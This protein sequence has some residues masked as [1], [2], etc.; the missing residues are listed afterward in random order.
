MP[1]RATTCTLLQEAL[2]LPRKPQQTEAGVSNEKE[3]TI[4]TPAQLFG[5]QL[6]ELRASIGL[7]QRE[8]V[9]RIQRRVGVRMDPATLARIEKADG[10]RVTLDEVFILAAGLGI[11]PLH[12]M[13]PREGRGTVRIGKSADNDFRVVREWLRGQEELDEPVPGGDGE[14]AWRL[15]ELP[16]EPYRHGLLKREQSLERAR[17]R[18]DMTLATLFH[19]EAEQARVRAAVTDARANVEHAD[20]KVQAGG[21]EKRL[22]EAKNELKA[23][24]AHLDMAEHRRAVVEAGYQAMS[25]EF[26]RAR[27]DFE[28][29]RVD[30]ETWRAKMNELGY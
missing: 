5:R 26:A 24:R 12:I 17:E 27:E 10:K 14:V 28:S 20:A 19:T 15:G 9:Q 3:T 4:V 29:A 13:A 25:E 16:D 22:Q 23:A 11:S 7:T 8:L 30:L 18:R 2:R 21:D 1:Q 6:A